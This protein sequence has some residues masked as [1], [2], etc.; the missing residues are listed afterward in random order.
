MDPAAKS[1]LEIVLLYPCVKVMFYHRIAH[2]LYQ[3]RCFFLA[4]LLSQWS[5]WLTGIEIHP[6]AT[7]GKGLFIDH[8][9]GVVIGETAI[10][11]DDVTMYH[12]VTIGG[13]GKSSGRRHPK[14]G[15]R[16]V[17]GTGAKVLG[18][19]TIGN[20]AKIGAN[21]VVLKDLPD[22]VTAVGI[23]AKI[24]SPIKQPHTTN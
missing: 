5:R 13:I 12:Q 22:G 11:G 9:D 21:A 18:G 15:D 17:I 10:I 16:V 7:I 6:G 14:I 3:W 19:I 24:V 8:G 1:W 23:P 2:K 20:D 4:R